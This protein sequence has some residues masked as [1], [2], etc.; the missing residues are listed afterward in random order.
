MRWNDGMKWNFCSETN[1]WNVSLCWIPLSMYLKK[2]ELFAVVFLGSS[3]DCPLLL[4]PVENHC[5]VSAGLFIRDYRHSCNSHLFSHS[6]QEA[7]WG[8]WGSKSFIS[9]GSSQLLWLSSVLM[10]SRARLSE[11][12]H[13]R[14]EA[15]EMKSNTG[16]LCLINFYESKA[17]CRG[18]TRSAYCW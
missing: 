17:H 9:V 2:I 11:M 6:R 1:A 16:N 10:N 12:W 4:P 13:Q 14:A 3:C 15:T 18:M 8:L 7:E 5:W